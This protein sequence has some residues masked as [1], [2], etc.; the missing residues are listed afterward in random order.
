[1]TCGYFCLTDRHFF[2]Y[3]V[4][5]ATVMFFYVNPFCK[6]S[7]IFYLQAAIMSYWHFPT[8]VNSTFSICTKGKRKI[9]NKINFCTWSLVAIWSLQSRQNKFISNHV[10]AVHTRQ[11]SSWWDTTSLLTAYS[12]FIKENWYWNSLFWGSTKP[13]YF[14]SSCSLSFSLT[15]L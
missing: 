13:T 10:T 3:L 15:H 2:P 8:S 11:S 6:Y 9:T 5:A 1:M 4:Q 12:L 14:Q 7:L